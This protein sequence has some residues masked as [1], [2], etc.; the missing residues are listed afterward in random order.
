MAPG[1]RTLA[2]A[3]EHYRGL[4]ARLLGC[5]TSEYVVVSAYHAADPPHQLALLDLAKLR[6]AHPLRLSVG[7]HYEARERSRW[8][9]ARDVGLAADLV[10]APRGRGRLD[11]PS[12]RPAGSAP[13]ARRARGYGLRWGRRR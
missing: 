11:A 7:E 2:E 9:P 4:T 12:A 3:V 6:A 13:P 10:R 5:L 8:R 1:S